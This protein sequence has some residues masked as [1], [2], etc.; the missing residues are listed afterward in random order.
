MRWRAR[1]S[2]H[3]RA[4]VGADGRRARALARGSASEFFLSVD[5]TAPAVARRLV[6]DACR[7]MA[8]DVVEV[9]RL[10]VSEVVT[11]A[12]THGEGSV[13]LV[14]ARTGAGVTVCV[15]DEN[16]D[17]PVVRER[18]P[19]G[20]SGAGMRLVA[21]LADDWGVTPRGDGLRGKRVWFSL[22]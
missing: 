16:P 18:R 10:L 4:G 2:E 8:S 20:E 5:L 21:A 7:E 3:V 1:R 15:D 19:L 17:H 14:I 9:A 11:N 12:I 6:A 22:L 13:L